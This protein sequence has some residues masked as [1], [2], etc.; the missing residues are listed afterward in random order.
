MAEEKKT[1]AEEIRALFKDMHEKLD[2]LCKGTECLPEI[3][4]GVSELSKKVDGIKISEAPARPDK[5]NV[6]SWMTFCPECGEKLREEPPAYE[7]VDCHVP[8][9]PKKDKVCWNCGSKKARERKK[10]ELKV[11]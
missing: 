5:H 9:D 6:F 3:S 4:K 7:C 10:E 2:K 1:E 11:K 8:V